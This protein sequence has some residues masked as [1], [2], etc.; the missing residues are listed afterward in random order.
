MTYLSSSSSKNNNDSNKK[1]RVGKAC[2]SCRLK[3]T[4]CNGKQP[5]ERC[6]LD[7]KFC[8]YTERKKSKDKMYSSEYV[9]LI[10]KRL[11]LV[12]KSLIKLCE[13]LKL[14]KSV[15]LEKFAKNLVYDQDNSVSPISINQAISLLIN[16][17]DD[18]DHDH[19]SDHGL[20]HEHE[21]NGHEHHHHN[22][23]AST[24][25]QDHFSTPESISPNVSQ[26]PPNLNSLGDSKQNEDISEITN[27]QNTP[28]LISQI[29]TDYLPMHNSSNS[30]LI[31][32]V[33]DNDELHMMG[34]NSL[35]LV[36]FRSNHN[37][38]NT[39]PNN[40]NNSNNNLHN[41]RPLLISPNSSSESTIHTNVISPTLNTFSPS[42]IT[43]D[44]SF[45]FFNN[46]NDFTIDTN[47]LLNTDNYYNV[48]SFSVNNY[49]DNQN[50]TLSASSPL[51]TARSP[52]ISSTVGSGSIKKVQHHNH[53]HGHGHA[54][55]HPHSHNHNHSNTHNHIKGLNMTPTVNSNI[56]KF[57]SPIST[58]LNNDDYIQF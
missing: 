5:C 16:T 51:I 50:L 3:K 54:H 28:I 42:S 11:S 27:V 47:S 55:N 38:I 33:D 53:G 8:I 58:E 36:N 32:P 48:N 34:F 9:E 15:E 18:F 35:D 40:N 56:T 37:A 57:T 24:E 49:N 43:S 39:I 46:L 12:N 1:K 7:N 2:D 13:L 30:N 21:H 20:A 4:K 10:D 45:L 29:E 52:S 25:K 44:S 26:T 22:H 6:I 19:E 14:N 17:N 31:S 23:D 41:Y